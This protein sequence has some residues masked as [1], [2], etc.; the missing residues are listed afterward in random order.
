MAKRSKEPIDPVILE[1]ARIM[2]R[3]QAQIDVEAQRQGKEAH[4]KK[5]RKRVLKPR[6]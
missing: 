2:G 5:P 4:R 3:R 1:I 6:S